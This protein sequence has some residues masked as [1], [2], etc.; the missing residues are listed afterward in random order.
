M[1]PR[2]VCLTGSTTLGNGEAI[3]YRM[4]LLDLRRCSIVTMCLGLSGGLEVF[5]ELIMITKAAL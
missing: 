1:T 4:I 3:V 2:N 5:V